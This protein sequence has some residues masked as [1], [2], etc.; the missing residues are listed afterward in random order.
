MREQYEAGRRR[1]D[2]DQVAATDRRAI[3][4]R[5]AEQ[6]VLARHRD[7]NGSVGPHT[8]LAGQASGQ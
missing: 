1:V 5:D 4:L 8:E 3:A 7:E 6:L 2:I